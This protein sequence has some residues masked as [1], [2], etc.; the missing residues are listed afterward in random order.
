MDM[1]E[2]NNQTKNTYKFPAVDQA[3]GVLLYL[4]DNGSTPKSL[5]NIAEPGSTESLNNAGVT[6]LTLIWVT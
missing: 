4:A 2:N 1:L 6:D 3:I 5:T